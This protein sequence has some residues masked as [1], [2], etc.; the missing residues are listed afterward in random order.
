MN[1]PFFC[2]SYKY[3]FWTGNNRGNIEVTEAKSYYLNKIHWYFIIHKYFL[4]AYI[5]IV[6]VIICKID[7]MTKN[8]KGTSKHQLP[9]PFK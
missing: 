3:N 8:M 1:F 6:I 2:I 5:I 9:S 4:C 7:F